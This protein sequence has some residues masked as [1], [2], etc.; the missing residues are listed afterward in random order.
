[1]LQNYELVPNPQLRQNLETYYGSYNPSEFELAKTVIVNRT[2]YDLRSLWNAKEYA[3]MKQYFRELASGAIEDSTA[4]AFGWGSIKK[5]LPAIA[6]GIG[7]AVPEAQPFINAAMPFLQASNAASGNAI[8]PSSAV[9][10]RVARAAGDND[11]KCKHAYSPA[12][13]NC[14]PKLDICS[15][16]YNL[17]TPGTVR[18]PLPCE[19]LYEMGI[20]RGVYAYH[21]LLK[22][23]LAPVEEGVCVYCLNTCVD[24][25]AVVMPGIMFCSHCYDLYLTVGDTGYLDHTTLNVSHAAGKNPL[26]RNRAIFERMLLKEKAKA[27]LPIEWVEKA[28]AFPTLTSGPMEIKNAY[29]LYAIVLGKSTQLNKAYGEYVAVAKSKNG[30]SV[31]GYD[32]PEGIP[33]DIL[34]DMSFLPVSPEAYAN[35]KLKLAFAADGAAWPRVQSTSCDGALWM[36]SNVQWHGVYPAAITGEIALRAGKAILQTNP[37][38]SLKAKFLHSFAIPLIANDECADE[39]LQ[40]LSLLKVVPKLRADS[41]IVSVYGAN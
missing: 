22:R 5:F 10:V 20:F 19:N 35:S 25:E 13:V 17:H 12:C 23:N 30:F 41:K 24:K 29:G 40:D 4:K 31:Y 15:T 1:V 39:N 26:I 18:N 8:M 27:H 14:N 11:V 37:M 21:E 16:C 28:I 33:Y 9:P 6:A 36:M 34:G 3:G 2:R 7:G 32:R 38:F